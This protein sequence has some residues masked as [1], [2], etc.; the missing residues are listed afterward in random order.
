VPQA[1]LHKLALHDSTRSISQ[2]CSPTQTF[3]SNDSV[4]ALLNER[5]GRGKLEHSSNKQN[6]HPENSVSD[7]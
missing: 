7:K 4:A 1:K 6:D 2:C 3:G 5:D